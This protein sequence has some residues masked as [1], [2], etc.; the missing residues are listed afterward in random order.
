MKEREKRRQSSMEDCIVNNT[1]ILQKNNDINNSA[2]THSLEQAPFTKTETN[3][4]NP[5]FF[6]WYSIH[7]FLSLT[8]SDL[9]FSTDSNLIKRKKEKEKHNPEIPKHYQQYCEKSTEA[10]I[11]W[12]RKPTFNGL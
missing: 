6:S 1:T 3:N 9:N 8:A 11:G 7:Y 5:I 10:M 12:F 2:R 4:L